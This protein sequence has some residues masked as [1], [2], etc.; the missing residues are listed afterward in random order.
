MFKSIPDI[1]NMFATQAYKAGC[2]DNMPICDEI[3]GLFGA[4]TQKK[5][6]QHI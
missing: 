4:K 1:E 2:E 5:H 6:P 3:S